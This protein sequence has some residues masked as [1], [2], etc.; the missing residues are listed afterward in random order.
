VAKVTFELDGK[1]VTGKGTTTMVTGIKSGVAFEKVQRS[2]QLDAKHRSPTQIE[3]GLARVPFSGLSDGDHILNILPDP[4]DRS[5]GAASPSTTDR[6][7]RLYRPLEVVVTVQNDKVKEAKARDSKANHGYIT[8]FNDT[9]LAIDLKPDWMRSSVFGSRSGSTAISLIVV[10]HTAG[11]II[12]GAIHQGLNVVG[13]HYEI[14]LDGHV[15]KFV[16]DAK[17]AWHAGQSRWNKV[18]VSRSLI[19]PAHFATLNTNR[20]RVSSRT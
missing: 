11:P 7:K 14:D 6:S 3:V 19:S 15:V 1:P 9:E 17:S 4:N 12:S 18:Q 2:S 20:F 5:S 8:A 10:H 16:E 13:P